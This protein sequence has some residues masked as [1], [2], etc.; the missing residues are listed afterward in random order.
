[1][2]LSFALVFI[3]VHVKLFTPNWSVYCLFFTFRVLWLSQTREADKSDLWCFLFCFLP[4]QIKMGNSSNLSWNVAVH[5]F[6]VSCT[7]VVF[8]FVFLWLLKFISDILH[9]YGFVKCYQ[10]FD[11][12]SFRILGISHLSFVW[13]CFTY[14][15][16]DIAQNVK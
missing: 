15:V 9:R 2:R 11:G 16:V 13:T 10:V 5:E 8:W 6:H 14:Y 1:M 12:Y 3:S 7:Y 4:V